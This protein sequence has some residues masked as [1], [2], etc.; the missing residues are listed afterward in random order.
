MTGE[1]KSR[2]ASDEVLLPEGGRKQLDRLLGEAKE[3]L[4]SEF[5]SRVRRRPAYSLRAFARD[6]KISPSSLVD[7]MKGRAGFS[8]TR[9]R[10]VSNH[11]GLSKTEADF[12][13]DLMQRDYSPNS[14]VRKAAEARIE[15]R[16]RSSPAYFSNE[17]FRLISDWYHLALLEI[18]EMSGG[19][20]SARELATR[21]K[22]EVQT[23]RDAI[24]RLMNLG[25]L[26]RSR[27]LLQPTSDWSVISSAV[28]SSAMREFHRQMLNLSYEALETQDVAKRESYSA[29]V[30]IPKSKYMEFRDEVCQ[31]LDMLVTKYG[32]DGSKDSV[33][34]MTLQTFEIFETRTEKT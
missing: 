28:P 15:F 10:D 26:V 31:A 29:F 14:K 13:W 19:M 23:V 9:T 27:G 24:N 21:L 34:G 20:V 12:F 3:Y 22:I 17:S 25:L 4:T 5:Q 2:T 30:S 11:I 18:I 16:I 8:R 33:V 6:L 7:L 1:V 32:S